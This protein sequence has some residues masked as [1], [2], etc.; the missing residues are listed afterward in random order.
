MNV[1]DM[2][3]AK[4]ET[5]RWRILCTL[6][7]GR[8]IGVSEMIIFRALSD[9]ELH[10]SPHEVREELDYLEKKDLAQT[11]RSGGNWS[12]ELTARGI[13]IVEYTAE[14]PAGISRPEKYW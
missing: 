2:D 14:C 10:L 11:K 4:R 8:P 12:A 6:N 1:I 3:R 13:D 7:A 9:A 5:A